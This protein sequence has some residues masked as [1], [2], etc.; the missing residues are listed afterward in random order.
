[1]EFIDAFK[2][3]YGR[4]DQQTINRLGEFY[5]EDIV[6][7]DPIHKIQGLN[8]L[9]NYFSGMCENLISCEFEFLG[10]TVDERSAWFKWVMHYQHPRLKKGQRLSVNGASYIHFSCVNG[11]YHITSHEDF[12]DMGEMLYE[13]TPLLGT[14]IRWIKQQLAKTA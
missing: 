6:F 2:R 14:G 4:F 10:Q 8:E 13:H 9:K 7:A 5:S 11:Q 1:M 12:Y 3:Y